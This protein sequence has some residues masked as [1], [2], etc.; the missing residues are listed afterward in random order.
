MVKLPLGSRL[1]QIPFS[2]QV[3]Q[4]K[5]G[6]K[7][8]F[9]VYNRLNQ[10]PAASDNQNWTQIIELKDAAKLY[11]YWTFIKLC[12][13]VEKVIGKPVTSIRPKA[14]PLQ[15]ELPYGLQVI[16]P[17]GVKV[18]YNKTYRPGPHLKR[19]IFT[20]CTPA[21][22]HMSYIRGVRRGFLLCETVYGGGRG[23]LALCGW[24]E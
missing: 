1:K 11:E 5:T 7:E 14:N 20:K 2:S 6:Y 8:I 17:G 18:Y 24:G 13:A 10:L 4:E 3:L 16:F 12:Q 15:A 21:G 9:T 23:N 22:V 19:K